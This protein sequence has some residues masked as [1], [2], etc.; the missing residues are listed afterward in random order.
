MDGRPKNSNG[1]GLLTKVI[2]VSFHYNNYMQ[3]ESLGHPGSSSEILL[4]IHI[5]VGKVVL[6]DAIVT[7]CYVPWQVVATRQRN[8]M[9][10]AL[11]PPRTLTIVWTSLGPLPRWVPGPTT[12]WAP[13]TTRLALHGT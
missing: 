9:L 7:S 10:L 12:R 5:L 4:R 11:A 8:I 6:V 2:I 3:K 1:I 13:G